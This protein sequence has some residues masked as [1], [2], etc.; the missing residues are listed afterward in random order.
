[1]TST[2]WESYILPGLQTSS[3]QKSNNKNN[4]LV[5]ASMKKEQRHKI[6][7]KFN[8]LSIH[9]V[10]SDSISYDF[11]TRAVYLL[12]P[13]LEPKKIF[14]L[15]ANHQILEYANDRR[16]HTLTPETVWPVTWSPH[17]TAEHLEFNSIKNKIFC[18][19]LEKKYNTTIVETSTIDHLIQEL[20]QCQ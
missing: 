17:F 10:I 2:Y 13:I 12:A 6:E 19:L 16:V 5:I 20:S 14:L 4:Y 7:E 11:V 1:M 9:F 15:G 8:D 3:F 18:E